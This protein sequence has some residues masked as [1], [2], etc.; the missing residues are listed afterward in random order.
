VI[1]EKVS[2]DDIIRI[3]NSAVSD[4]KNAINELVNTRVVC[5]KKL[6]D[7]ESIQVG[8]IDG[9]YRVGILGILNGIFGVDENE[10]GV[11][12]AEFD[13]EKKLVRFIRFKGNTKGKGMEIPLTDEVI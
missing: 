7:H 6:A 2:V 9:K 5:N 8:K 13:K 11:I 1:N 12:A 4:D 10:W 3:L